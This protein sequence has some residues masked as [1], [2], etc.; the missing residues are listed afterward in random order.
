MRLQFVLTDEHW[1]QIS[2]IGAQMHP[3]HLIEGPV[4]AGKSTFS[5]RLARQLPGVHLAL[6]EWFVRLYS[7]DRPG[8]DFV[9]WY[10]QRKERLLELMWMHAK[11]LASANANPIL[12]LGLIQRQARY[13]FYEQ[14]RK[15]GIQLNVYL[16]DAPEN[17]RW[18]RVEHRN[19][20]KGETFSM[21]VPRHIFEVASA[22]WEPPDDEEIEMQTI[23]IVK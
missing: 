7:P 10:L 9:N 20:S 2:K 23:E 14:A 21:A 6:D 4:G 1:R 8:T 18:E 15:E 13:R 11:N 22:M 16:L 5:R 12:E 3:I 19:E 17:I